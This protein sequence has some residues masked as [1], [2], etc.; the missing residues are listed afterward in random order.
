MYIRPSHRGCCFSQ[1][2]CLSFV[3]SCLG[4]IDDNHPSTGCTI[5]IGQWTG[6]QL[7]VDEKNELSCWDVL[8]LKHATSRLLC[9][10]RFP[11]CTSG[12]CA[13]RGLHTEP[14]KLSF[15]SP[16]IL[17]KK[18]TYILTQKIT[19]F[20]CREV[21][22]LMR[23]PKACFFLLHHLSLATYVTGH[24]PEV[25]GGRRILCCIL[26]HGNH[27]L[28]SCIILRH[29]F[30]GISFPFHRYCTGN[31]LLHRSGYVPSCSMT[32]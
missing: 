10:A 25:T 9:L 29:L 22:P 13:T 20:L 31:I 27:I 32:D 7:Q 12:T 2:S 28:C 16:L 21:P 17:A 30:V 11:S 19:C 18:L 26:F 5:G 6:T 24:T 3:V 15:D 4:I 14:H 8:I 23:R 1:T